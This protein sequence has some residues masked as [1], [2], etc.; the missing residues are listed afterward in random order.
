MEL[1]DLGVNAQTFSLKVRLLS[2]E[3]EGIDVPLRTLMPLTMP[4]SQAAEHFGVNIKTIR[5]WIK[6]GKLSGTQIDGRWYVEISNTD[7]LQMSPDVPQM[8]S[9]ALAE[10]QSLREQLQRADSE[11]QFLREQSREQLQRRDEQINHLTQ[12]V[13]M[14]QKNIGA[15]TEQLDDSRQM[16]EDMRSRSWWKRIFRR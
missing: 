15:L 5:R 14:S 8:S 16:I 12:V 11:I 10:T 6:S 9:D 2:C 13:A 3:T 7:A 1:V 4:S